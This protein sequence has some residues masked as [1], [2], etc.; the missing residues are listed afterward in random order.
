MISPLIQLRP[1]AVLHRLAGAPPPT[2]LTSRSSS[3]SAAS[4]TAV[5]PMSAAARAIVDEG[6]DWAERRSPERPTD[7]MVRPH[8]QAWLSGLPAACW[9]M[10]LASRYPRLANQ[11]ALAWPD[12][13]LCERSLERLLRDERGGRRG[14]PSAVVLELQALRR[15]RHVQG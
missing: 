11:I 10:E 8:T 9:P 7:Q 13:A 5:R 6:I 15:L 14:F 3:A 1:L 12:A 4:E 2:P